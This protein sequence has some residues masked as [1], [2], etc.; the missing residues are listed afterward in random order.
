VNERLEPLAVLVKDLPRDGVVEPLRAAAAAQLGLRRRVRGVRL[1]PPEAA[2]VLAQRRLLPAVV[3]G[4][5]RGVEPRFERLEVAVEVALAVP[6]PPVGRREDPLRRELA[7]QLE[8]LTRLWENP[9]EI[10]VFGVVVAER[11]EELAEPLGLDQVVVDQPR[12]AGD[13]LVETEVGRGGVPVLAE[14]LVTVRVE[15]PDRGVGQLPQP[16]PAVVDDALLHLGR[17]APRERR[18][19]DVRRLDVGTVDDRP[20]APGDGERLPGPRT[21]V[22]EVRPLGA[23]DQLPL[24]LVRS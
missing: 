5:V 15:R 14:E 8:Q 4:L 17:G 19:Q 22:G 18:Q 12:R 13:P 1:V 11:A 6:V 24:S 9:I 21:G 23:L 7:D 2:Q 3:P 16:V 20:V 10:G